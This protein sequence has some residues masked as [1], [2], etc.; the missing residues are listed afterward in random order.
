MEQLS[1]DI[2][3]QLFLLY[4]YPKATFRSGIFVFKE[5]RD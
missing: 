5:T 4:F 3:Y 2:C 1:V